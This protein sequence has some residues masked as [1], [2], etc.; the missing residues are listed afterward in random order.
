[1]YHRII[2]VT[3]PSGSGK[4]HLYNQLIN[5]NIADVVAVDADLEWSSSA[6]GVRNRYSVQ[7]M[8]DFAARGRPN[9]IAVMFGLSRNILEVLNSF[10]N[11]ETVSPGQNA[12]FVIRPGVDTIVQ[13]RVQRGKPFDRSLSELE[14]A[15][16]V[17]SF[18]GVLAQVKTTSLRSSDVDEFITKA[19]K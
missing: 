10:K 18:D 14:H 6:D 15:K 13:R 9:Q 5:R 11:L 1:M 2:F 3:G 16:D 19:F 12:I 17:K 4:T 7:K 8:K